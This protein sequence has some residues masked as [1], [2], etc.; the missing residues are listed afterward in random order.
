M[1]TGFAFLIV[2]L[3]WAAVGGPSLLTDAIELGQSGLS[4]EEPLKEDVEWVRQQ[5]S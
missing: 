3:V 1:P 5:K 4:N 2:V